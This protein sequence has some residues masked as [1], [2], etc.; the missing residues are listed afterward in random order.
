MK[1]GVRLILASTLSGVMVAPVHAGPRLDSI[2]QRG[3]LICGVSPGVAGFSEVDSRGRYSGLDVDMCRA[4]AAAIFGA[5]DKVRYV[6][7]PS[8]Q[9]FLRVSEIDIV[10]RRLTWSLTRERPLGLLFGPIIFYDGQGFL[11]PKV[12]GVKSVRQLSGTSVCV[13]PGGLSEANLGPYFRTHNLELKAVPLKS[14]GEVPGALE[15]GTCHAYTADVSELGSI[16]SKMANPGDFDILPEQISKEPLAQL[17]RQDDAAFF[18][19][20]RWTVFATIEAEE[21]GR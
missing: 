21:A 19:I 2:R 18:D 16:R 11:V 8:V 6:Q 15:A 17:V 4:I 10:S 9:V 7:A 20:L 5:P 14:A 3:F 12:H 1:R 13:Q